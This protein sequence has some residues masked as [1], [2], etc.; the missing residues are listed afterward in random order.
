MGP[1]ALEHLLSPEPL[2]VCPGLPTQP[3]GPGSLLLCLR[4]LRVLGGW[5]DGGGDLEGSFKERGGTNSPLGKVRTC[6]TDDEV[7]DL[8]KGLFLGPNKVG[9][10]SVFP[11]VIK[12]PLSSFYNQLWLRDT[13]I[14][15]LQIYNLTRGH[16]C[17]EESLAVMHHRSCSGRDHQ[18]HLP[19]Y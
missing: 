18:P 19:S 15:L 5:R 1:R 13:R 2:W 16:L 4:L 11:S 14:H 12:N 17:R 9:L 3:S 7:E 10:W 8:Q 6:S